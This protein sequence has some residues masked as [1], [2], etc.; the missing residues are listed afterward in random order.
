MQRGNDGKFLKQ[1]EINENFFKSIENENQAYILGFLYADGCNYVKGSDRCV[2]FAQLE[3]DIDILNKIRNAL[4]YT[5][6]NLYKEIQKSNGKIRY[7]LAIYNRN[8]SED[9]EKLGV[10]PN[11]SLILQFPTFIPESLMRH[12]IRG[13]FDGDGCI[14]EGKPK[15][16]SKNRFI[17]NVKFTFTGCYTFINSLQDYLIEHLGFRKTKL[18]Y[19]KAKNPNNNTSENVCTMEYSG[20]KQIE[21]LYHYLYD[22]ASIYGFRKKLKFEGIICA[23]NKKL[24]FETRLTA[25][26]P[27]M[28]ISN[29]A[30]DLN[31]VEGSSTIPEMEVE[32]SDS[33]CLALSIISNTDIDEGEDIVSSHINKEI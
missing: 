4:E 8:I 20:K 30:T 19:S 5:N 15:I 29:Q 24:L 31:S 17:H 18:N 14:W 12:F 28:V 13:Y 22:D 23:N 16:D 27:E 21:K 6:P 11:K 25:G 7:T 3:Q 2:S 9:V 33:K 1:Y 26:T 10:V 32:S